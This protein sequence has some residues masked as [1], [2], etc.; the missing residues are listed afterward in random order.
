M[1]IAADVATD[2]AKNSNT[3]ATSQTV[4]I[5][6]YRAWDV[7]EDG[8]V[9]VADVTLVVSALGQSGVGIVNP[10]TDVNGDGTVDNTD[11]LL[12]VDNLD[13][14]NQNAA[15]LANR[16]IVDFLIDPVALETLDRD[17]LQA[18]LDI[19]RTESDESLK[20]LRAIALLES[21]LEAM[22]PE[23][24]LLLANY[25]NP[26]NP[27]TWIPY[28]LA[29]P[30]DVSITIYDVTGHVVRHLD[31]GHQVAGFYSNR[32][33]AAYWD[34]RN[35]VGEKVASGVYFYTLIAGDFTATRKL[36]ILK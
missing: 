11:L 25:P 12:V 28:Q 10:R 20:Y 35:A 24:T 19:L 27:E 33:S 22:R 7:N 4:N 6:M 18:H 5:E 34:G 8:N 16:K 17:V 36:L 3:A 9:D 13:S 31:L 14:S 2:A 26:F 30:N 29:N 32:D 1:S 15:P 23:Q 21:I